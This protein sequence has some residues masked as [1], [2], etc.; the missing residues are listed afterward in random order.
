MS[1]PESTIQGLVVAASISGLSSESATVPPFA[2]NVLITPEL[3]TSE[4]GPG[5]G[6]FVSAL[7]GGEDVPFL[8]SSVR[9]RVD[10]V[11]VLVRSHVGDYAGGLVLARAVRAAIHCARPSG[12]YS[13]VASDPT[14]AYAGRD[15]EGRHAWTIGVELRSTV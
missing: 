10:R 1:S 2:G 8:G 7:G 6:V 3:P 9:H 14:P 11:S 4:G 12:Y 13:C 5:L 15:E